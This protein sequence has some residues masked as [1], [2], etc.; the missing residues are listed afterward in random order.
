MATYNGAK[1][2]RQQLESLVAQTCAPDQLVICDDGS[3][4]GTMDILYEFRQS[5]P[6]EVQIVRNC[7]NLGYVRNFEKALS[8]CSRD[9]IFLSDQDDLWF[10]TKLE[11]MSERME[12]DPA[13]QVLQCDM[14]LTDADL[15]PSPYTQL[16][17]IRAAGVS[18]DAFVTG[19]GTALRREWLAVC[20]PFPYELCGHDNWIH[21]LAVA[22]QTRG[23]IEA[24]LQHFRRHGNNT[25]S[26]IVSNPSSIGPLDLLRQ[27][28]LH[29]VT[30]GWRREIDRIAATA[31]RIGERMEALGRMGLYD[32]VPVAVAGLRAEISDRERRLL[33]SRQSRLVRIPMVFEFW[34]SGGY[35]RFSNWRSAIKDIIRP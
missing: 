3:T 32:R 16:G 19:C 26:W 11:I 2:L 6:F 24:P 8:L 18:S 9:I 21:R 35:R 13:L 31:D 30:E 23:L 5:A 10:P 15:N 20:F 34:W 1:Y 4:D 7:E 33:I 27:S 29:D 28:G 14:V 12:E 17:N 25:S 22:L